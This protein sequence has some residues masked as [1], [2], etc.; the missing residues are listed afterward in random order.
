M[1]VKSIPRFIPLSYSKTV[2]IG[3][4]IFIFA[5]NI[6]FGFQPVP[7]INIWGKNKID[8]NFFQLNFVQLQKNLVISWT[9]FRNGTLQ[10]I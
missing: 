3:V 5:P 1:S 2:V 10:T 6:D 4:Y 9:C 8:I 7:I